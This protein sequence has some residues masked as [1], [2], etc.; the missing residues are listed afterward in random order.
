MKNF[1]MKNKT[2]V[3]QYFTNRDVKVYIHLQIF[4]FVNL[5]LYRK[6]KHNKVNTLMLLKKEIN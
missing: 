5:F 1:L 2:V 3:S 6:V 4:Y